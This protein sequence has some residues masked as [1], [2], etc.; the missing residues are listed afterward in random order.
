M[1]EPG[2]TSLDE[3]LAALADHLGVELPQEVITPVLDLARDAAHNVLRPAAPL[4][5]FVAG[6]AA[7]LAGGPSGA[8]TI[9][10]TLERARA[11]AA[12]WPGE[13]RPPAE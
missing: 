12:E 7:G 3:W 8:A 4:S 11:F 13:A 5:T 2:T 6:Y 1:T 10:D 9:L